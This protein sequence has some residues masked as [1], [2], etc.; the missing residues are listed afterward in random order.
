MRSRTEAAPPP[1][2]VPSDG[3]GTPEDRGRG[4]G[5]G[6]LLWVLGLLIVGLLA[7]A[8]WATFWQNEDSPGPDV[9]VT[10]SDLADQ[11]EEYYGQR[12]VVSG[13]IEDVLDEDGAV[14]AGD[15]G[16]AGFV[17]GDDAGFLVVGSNIPELA[18]IGENEQ[19]AEGD[20]VQVTG[21]VQ[22]FDRAGFQ[23]EAGVEL[24]EG[25]FDDFD[26]RPAIQAMAV[27]LVPVVPTQGEQQQVAL[28]ALEDD[29]TEFLGSQV[30][31][32]GAEIEE[33]ISPR[34]AA[35][36]D[37]VLLITPPN[38]SAV[39]QGQAVEVTGRVVEVSTARLANE[40]SLANQDEL[41]TELE[42]EEGDIDDYDV[43]VIA[44]QITPQQ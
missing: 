22:A 29:P 25:V 4:S 30:T 12:V 5:N 9:G 6:P 20:V 39:T 34:V 10:L 33:L 16:G 8:L 11:P 24:E 32:Q 1:P 36:S 37:D 17:L 44:G 40:L 7:W 19:I 41:F 28:E 18:T 27:S 31:V 35:L 13:Q 3:M 26:D 21:V 38:A 15:T 43:A 42:I 14:D 2:Y 23:D